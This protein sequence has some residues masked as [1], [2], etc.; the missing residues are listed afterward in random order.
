MKS[1]LNKQS[2]KRLN[3]E[4]TKISKIANA[5]QNTNQSVSAAIKQIRNTALTIK[6]ENKIEERT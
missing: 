6:Q 4:I 3:M 5:Q 1:S 2:V